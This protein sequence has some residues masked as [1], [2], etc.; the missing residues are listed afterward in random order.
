[1]TAARSPSAASATIGPL[2]L[3]VIGVDGLDPA[4]APHARTGIVRTSRRNAR[5]TERFVT[6]DAP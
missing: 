2:V 1:M 4:A 5:K 3:S 6:Y